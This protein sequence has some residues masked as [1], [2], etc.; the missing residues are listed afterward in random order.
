[1][2]VWI[3]YVELINWKHEITYLYGWQETYLNI[4]VVSS[5]NRGWVFYQKSAI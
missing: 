4:D 1:M 2:E 5:C 3:M